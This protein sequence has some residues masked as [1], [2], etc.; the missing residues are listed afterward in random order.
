KSSNASHRSPDAV[1]KSSGKGCVKSI[2]SVKHRSDSEGL[3]AGDGVESAPPDGRSTGERRDATCSIIL[4]E[5]M[6]LP[7]YVLAGHD[8]YF[9]TF[10]HE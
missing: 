10:G 5:H 6:T 3:G 1:G 4:G 2:T 9:V 7:F 8:R